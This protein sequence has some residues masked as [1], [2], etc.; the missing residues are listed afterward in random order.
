MDKR[1]EKKIELLNVVSYIFIYMIIENNKKKQGKKNIH[2]I[3]IIK[4]LQNYKNRIKIKEKRIERYNNKII[5][6]KKCYLRL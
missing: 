1:D 6:Q 3:S 5:R 2:N 4:K